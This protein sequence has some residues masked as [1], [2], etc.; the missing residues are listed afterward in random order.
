MS[1]EVRAS[2]AYDELC[3]VSKGCTLRDTSGA[4]RFSGRLPRMGATTRV[5]ELPSRKPY[6]RIGERMS[7]Y[8]IVLVFS[9]GLLPLAAEA[10]QVNCFDK[11][12]TQADLNSCAGDEY[13]AADAELNRVYKQI[14]EKYKDEPKFIAKLRAAQRAW[15]TYRD[16]EL[17][18]KFPHA[19]EKSAYYGSIFPMCD[20]QYKAG[21]TRERVAKLREWLDGVEEGDACS[22]SVMIK[23]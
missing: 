7:R 11:A 3:P 18:A 5:R 4:E 12:Q 14:L 6:F 19:D 23:Q 8:A 20:S 1:R 22:G 13:A 9:C 21:L 17:D 16:A 2:R 15:L 10:A